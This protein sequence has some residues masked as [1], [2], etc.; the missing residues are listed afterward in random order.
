MKKIIL[1]CLAWATTTNILLFAQNGVPIT[2]V[3]VSQIPTRDVKSD[4]WNKS[5]EAVI[6]VM[7]QN[8][9]NPQLLKASVTNMK[10][11]SV[12][13][14]NKIAILMEWTDSTRDATVA[15]DKFSDQVAI[16]LPMNPDTVPNYMMGNKKG[17]VHIIH[18]KALW[19]D[20]IEKGFQD[21]KTAHPNYWTDIYYFQEKKSDGTTTAAKDATV[22]QFKSKE[23]K[24]YMAGAYAGNPMSIFDRKEPSEEALSE[25]Y[26]TLAT[27]EKQDAAAWGVWENN[28]WK[29]II[30]RALNSSD[31]QDAP[32]LRN[33]QICFAVWNGSANNIG[34]KKHYS[35][36]NDLII[37]K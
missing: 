23:A 19:Q 2:S 8:V 18:W 20:D 31:P 25:G 26:G 15:V 37:G 12:N 6:P 9:T 34:A 13:D 36:W 3:R 16:Q 32:L 35:M 27:Q 30:V 29:V 10:V 17:R 21:V 7:P 28:T 5:Q 4:I 24:N 14:G 11:K 22:D 33:T 1:S